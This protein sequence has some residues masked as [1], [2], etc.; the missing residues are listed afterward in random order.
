LG[1]AT[2]LTFLYFVNP[3]FNQFAKTN[4]YLKYQPNVGILIKVSTVATFALIGN[5]FANSKRK[6][7]NFWVSNF[8]S[9][10]TFSSS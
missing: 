5:Y 3:L 1:A 9:N 8:V 7:A 2:G 6:A 10:S 4:P